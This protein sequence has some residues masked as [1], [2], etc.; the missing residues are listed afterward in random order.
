MQLKT[1]HLVL[2]LF[3]CNGLIAQD[4]WTFQNDIQRINVQT[5]SPQTSKIRSVRLNDTLI[6]A[7]IDAIDLTKKKA[8]DL[9]FFPNENG[10]LESF[11]LVSIPLFANKSALAHPSIKA[12]R[13]QSTERINVSVRITVTPRG[14]SGTMRTSSGF[15]FFQPAN[16]SISSYVFYQ[17][18]DIF[19]DQEES[20]FCTTE[21]S[22][23]KTESI[24]LK[25]ELA[26]K[27]QLTGSL[28]TYRFAV[29]TSGEYT[30]YWGDDDDTNGDNTQDALAAVANTIN[31]MNEIFEVDLGVRLLLV[32]NTAIIYDNPEEDPFDDNLNSEIQGVLTTEVGE[33][34]YD[35]GHLFHR[36]SANGNAGSIGNVCE[37]F[38]K[39][40]GFS[41]HPFTSTNGSSGGFL[42]DYFDID[43]V[44]HEVGHQFGGTH[45]YSHE[46][47]FSGVNSEPGSGSSIMS[48][49]GIVS[50]Q[51][52]Q[53]HSDPYF[54]Y[55]NIVQINAYLAQ[56]SCQQVEVGVNQ[57]PTVFAGND[58]TIPIG[59]AYVL[60]AVAQDSDGDQ[61]TYC[62]E[63]LDSGIVRSQD[64]GPQIIAG[65]MNRSLPPNVN[66]TRTI[67]RLAAI[68]SGDLTEINPFL[69]S[70]WETVSMVERTLRWGVTVRDRNQNAPNGVGFTAQ[71][72]KIISVED[73]AGPFVVLSQ[74]N[75]SVIWRAG[76]NELI[77]WD[78]ART[79]RA[80]IN[81]Q[82]VSIY[83][84]VDGGQSFPYPLVENT[85]NN[86]K[87]YIVV[88]AGITS[89]NARIKIV[90]DE[91]IYFAVNST[92]FQVEERSFALPFVEVA[93]EN[94]GTGN[95]RFDLN[96]EI[97]DAFSSTV[98]LSITGLP[99]AISASINP[100]VVQTDGT[101][102]TLELVT[103]E[104]ITGTYSATLVGASSKTQVEQ[105]F[106]IRFLSPTVPVPSVQSPADLSEN[107]PSFVN[108]TWEKSAEA[109]LYRFELSKE[110]DF[111]TTVVNENLLLNTI[112]VDDLEGLTTYYWRVSMLNNCGVSAPSSVQQFST[113]PIV[114]QTFTAFDAPFPI[115]DATQSQQGVTEVLIAVVDSLTVLDIDVKLRLT[116]TF[117]GDLS[118][119]LISPAGDEVS[120]I[121]NRGGEGQNF[122][123][124][125]FDAEAEPRITSA[126][127]PFTGTFR[128]EGDLTQF[129]GSI[130]RGIWRLKI[131]DS[132]PIDT[133]EV[134]L[135]ALN[136]CFDGQP[137]LNEDTDLIPSDEDNCPLI[138][139]SDQ[140]D[141]DS[142]G[143]GD[144][145]DIDAQRNF[146][147]VKSDETCIDR[148]N[149]SIII[150]SV[151]QFDYD[152]DVI[153]PSGF[154]YN[155]PFSD[156]SIAFDGLQSGD[157]LLCITSDDVPDFEQCFTVSILEP[158]PLSV[159]ANIN[160]SASMVTLD[161][162]GSKE[163]IIGLNELVFEANNVSEK[164]LPLDKGLNVITVKTSLSCQGEYKELIYIDEP[165]L[166]YPNPVVDE[167]AILVGGSAQIAEVFVYDIQGNISYY[168]EFLMLNASRQILIDV[169]HLSQGNYIVKVVTSTTEENLR[170][171]KQ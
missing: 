166:L 29:A 150:S 163:Y 13:G 101:T 141:T 91:N 6:R 58:V 24:A 7:K 168:K 125:T 49:A 47:E 122:N 66:S 123:N 61:L 111:S 17:R 76:A 33:S 97:F 22:F 2:L 92:P 136:F 64:F 145:C 60:N 28:K 113:A 67:P 102:V 117:V 53:R 147:I 37:S 19:S 135:F 35:V 107:L 148:N 39:G 151:A 51:N 88:P 137:Q 26:T 12:Y 157:Y 27:S 80:P 62:W 116:H 112:Q 73:D 56:N 121:R 8:S 105:P 15:L 142:D 54:H 42:T 50:G 100:L 114:C 154:R 84:S 126:S 138:T 63:Q 164:T 143:E 106:F 10:H 87:A 133:G 43:Y 96:F 170:F 71:D 134:K 16:G 45:T 99:P 119:R 48:Y 98:S 140:L 160:A 129:Y 9:F 11:S 38:K 21:N 79:N 1:L 153:G 89:A 156:E 95:V 120:L 20:L 127:A 18:K 171:I 93:K 30:Q 169:N 44:A 36:G 52:L 14:L 59:T 131:I 152:I 159:N 104:T 144:I 86:G 161:L 83:L 155:S 65:S 124:T 57:V 25:N 149:G 128:P 118:I 85:L 41:S 130:A 78:V 90:A 167:V 74:D 81:T 94:C 23:P 165:S 31:R 110:Q 115:E 139:N 132:G 4:Y 82:T 75:L 34:N 40:S 158:A 46:N 5:V 146:T 32:S 109:D 103:D 3:F 72:E 162:S 77:E 55:H 68:L 70:G 69:N 108:F